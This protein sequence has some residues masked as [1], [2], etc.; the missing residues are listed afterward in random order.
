MIVSRSEAVRQGLK[1][2]YTG[3]PCKRGHLSERRVST[4][5]CVT[6]SKE[7]QQTKKEKDR[8]RQHYI[9]NKGAY[10]AKA[11]K[12]YQEKRDEI[13]EYAKQY[14][15]ENAETINRH[16]AARV[17]KDDKSILAER[18]R[19]LIKES[20]KSRG[21]RKDTKTYKILGCTIEY[22]KFHIEKQFIKGMCWENFKEWHIDH[23]IPISS[24]KTQE[25]VIKL[26]HFTNLDRDWET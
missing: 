26:N 4:N 1:K 17:N 2:Y 16:R 24:A 3:K 22:F 7:R 20:I 13:I 6:C 8:K 19:C 21:H 18:I 9:D 15:K 10:L 5:D 12:R 14:A 23:I 25:D 11:S